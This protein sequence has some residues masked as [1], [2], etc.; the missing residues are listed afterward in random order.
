ME[1]KLK[2]SHLTVNGRL[3]F[4]RTVF[5]NQQHGT[6]VPMDLLLGIESR[7]YSLGVREICC[8]ESR[9]NAFVPA[10]ENVKRLAQLNISSHSVRQIVEQQGAAVSRAQYKGQTGPDFMVQDCTNQ[11]AITDAASV[12]RGSQAARKGKLFWNFNNI[13]GL[14]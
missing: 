11:T 9:N 14:R 12:I 13:R 4:Y 6:V 10:S 7:N 5:W 2:T 1:G 8:R 3:E